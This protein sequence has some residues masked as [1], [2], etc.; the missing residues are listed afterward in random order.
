MVVMFPVSEGFT[1][2]VASTLET[3]IA[4][5]AQLA[6]NGAEFRK[7]VSQNVNAAQTELYRLFLFS[8]LARDEQGSKLAPAVFE[9][10]KEKTFATRDG[11]SGTF[12]KK[13]GGAW[14]TIGNA[15]KSVLARHNDPMK[16]PRK[17]VDGARKGWTVNKVEVDDITY[18]VLCAFANPD[19][20]CSVSAYVVATYIERQRTEAAKANDDEKAAQRE[21]DIE[22]VTAFIAAK[23]DEARKANDPYQMDLWDDM[24]ARAA[25]VGV[26][27]FD[28]R[29]AI[30]TGN[31]IITAKREAYEAEQAAMAARAALIANVHSVR[32]MLEAEYPEHDGIFAT[33]AAAFNGDTQTGALMVIRRMTAHAG[34]LDEARIKATETVN[35]MVTDA[36]SADIAD[37]GSVT[38]KGRNRKPKVA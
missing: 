34:D 16:A 18:D 32:T 24:D 33:M 14:R 25:F 8:H 30:D 13:Y 26:P 23:R 15:V 4:S 2:S 38:G 17:G 36:P 9:S 12:E 31:A 27:P 21:R 1:T 6:I 29:E 22:A 11:A 7:G 20:V 10:L 3:K 19:N 35:A 37:I 28:L 5:V